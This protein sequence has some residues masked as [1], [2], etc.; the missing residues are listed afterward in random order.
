M[1]LA[2]LY[3][4]Q[5]AD[6]PAEDDE[7]QQRHAELRAAQAP[8]VEAAVGGGLAHLLAGGQRCSHRR[9]SATWRRAIGTVLP[10]PNTSTAVPLK[11]GRT[12]TARL[13]LAM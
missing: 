5:R 2:W 13:R 11:S 4:R 3:E 6:E 1:P 8:Q 10:S 9:S 7:R 12:S